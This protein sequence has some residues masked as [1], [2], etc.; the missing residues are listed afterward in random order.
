V[1]LKVTPALPVGIL[2][3]QQF[4]AAVRT[5]RSPIARRHFVHC[6]SG[7]TVGMIFFLLLIPTILIGWNDNLRHLKTW[8]TEVVA[9]EHFGETHRISYH[10][11]HNQSLDNAAHLL[12]NWLAYTFTGGGR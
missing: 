7:F 11:S 9:N 1:V 4:I 10:D 3:F 5:E 2:L 12:G 8:Y 6:V